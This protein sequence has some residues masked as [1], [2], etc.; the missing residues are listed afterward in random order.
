MTKIT[1]NGIYD[2]SMKE[3]RGQ[4]CDGMSLSASDAIKLSESTPLH[5]RQSWL[6]PEKY[7]PAA[8][9]GSI[10]HCLALEP[11]RKQ[12]AVKVIDADD[13]RT[14]AAQQARDEAL[15]DGLLPILPHTLDAA[16]AAVD[17]IMN[18]QQTAKLLDG[19]IAE[20]SYFAKHALGVWTKCRPDLVNGAQIIVDVKTCGSVHPEFIRRRIYDGGW[21]QQAPF[22]CDVYQR[23]TD[24]EPT[25]YIWLCVEQ[26]PPHAVA[27][28]RPTAD[29]MAAGARKNA[30]AIATF[31]EC[32]RTGQW[33]G[34]P[35]GVTELGLPDF[36]H[37]R[38]E[39]EALAD[40]AV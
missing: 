36:A 26:K 5:L 21:Y 22:H 4:P 37:Y 7:N 17:A 24:R 40:E 33:P 27:V 16:N 14:K 25:D 30:L 10:I 28:Y 6:E 32:V 34:Y 1:A 11:L 35:S 38:L 15:A 18:N 39:E 13:F 2:L 23:T 29:T 3:Y 9:L 20:Q 19:G 8:N 31:A 12:S